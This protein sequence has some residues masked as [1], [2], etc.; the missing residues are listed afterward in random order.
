MQKK[1]N[2]QFGE[3]HFLSLGYLELETLFLMTL[4]GNY[5]LNKIF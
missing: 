3:K 2:L 1:T 5:N 4:R